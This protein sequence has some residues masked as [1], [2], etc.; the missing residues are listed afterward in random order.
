[1]SAKAYIKST[2]Q[3]LLHVKSGN[4]CAKC[5]GL[6]VT[7]GVCIGENAHIYGEKPGSARYDASQPASFVQSDANLIFLC[8]SCHT[9]IDRNVTEYPATR[10]FEMKRLHEEEI[11]RRIED[12]APKIG[13]EELGVII[14][15]IADQYNVSNSSDSADLILIEIKEKIHKNCL[16][17]IQNYIT[18]GLSMANLIEDYFNRTPDRRFSAKV[19]A[20][21]VTKYRELRQQGVAGIE[22]FMILWDFIKGNKQSYNI[23]TAALG[24]LVYFY[25]KCEVFEK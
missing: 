9:I 15:Y 5:K 19:S 17:E 3:K 8:S 18:I 10:L 20:V 13:Y 12:A 1:M 6:L 22:A 23:D 16:S 24:L 4:S 21:V 11:V 7:E 25:E 14:N 2:E